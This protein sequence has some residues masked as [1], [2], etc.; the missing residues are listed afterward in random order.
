MADNIIDFPASRLSDVAVAEMI[1]L[2]RGFGALRSPRRR[3]LV[4]DTIRQFHL[5]E[6][7]EA[8]TTPGVPEL[9]R[10]VMR[11][12]LDRLSQSLDRRGRE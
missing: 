3:R 4:I 8:S 10:D 5:L 6:T 11:H 1:E 12:Y 2:L 7:A 9:G